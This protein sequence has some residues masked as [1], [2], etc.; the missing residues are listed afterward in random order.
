MCYPLD[1]IK[2][3]IKTSSS[4]F[5]AETNGLKEKDFVRKLRKGNEEILISL[6]HNFCKEYNLRLDDYVDLRTFE[7]KKA[8][9]KK[10]LPKKA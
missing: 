9:G 6:S 2:V 10:K 5:M 3:Y 7:K 4:K 8:I 1:T